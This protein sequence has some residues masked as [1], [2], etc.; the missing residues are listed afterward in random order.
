MQAAEGR[1]EELAALNIPGERGR[2]VREVG[3][4]GARQAGHGRHL[5][6]GEGE[7]RRGAE[8]EGRPQGAE[9][10]EEEGVRQGEGTGMEFNGDQVVCH[11][12]RFQL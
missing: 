1:A 3:R 7:A 4:V 12:Q 2:R 5:G 11:L 6:E 8:G 10:G 9:E